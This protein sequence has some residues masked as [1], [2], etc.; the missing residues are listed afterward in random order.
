[1]DQDMKISDGLGSDAR[2]RFPAFQI[3]LSSSLGFE[4]FIL[5]YL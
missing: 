2:N 1:M 5:M 3:Q 4:Q